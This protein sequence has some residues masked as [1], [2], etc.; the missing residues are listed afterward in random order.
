MKKSKIPRDNIILPIDTLIH[1]LTFLPEE[2]IVNVASV[3][4]QHYECIMASHSKHGQY[5]WKTLYKRQWTIQKDNHERKP[6]LERYKHKYI[7]EEEVNSKQPVKKSIIVMDSTIGFAENI[8]NHQFSY[9]VDNHPDNTTIMEYSSD[10]RLRCE[11]LV[12]C[13]G[14][15]CIASFRTATHRGKPVA[16]VMV[17]AFNI[18]T[19]RY[20]NVY[21]KKYFPCQFTKPIVTLKKYELVDIEDDY[22][23]LMIMDGDKMDT[24]DLNANCDDM[25]RSGLLI[26]DN[27]KTDLDNALYDENTDVIIVTVM[28]ACGAE[29]IINYE[30]SRNE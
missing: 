23:V 5:L 21:Q 15:P 20:L 16:I 4:R 13:D 18:F 29:R 10:Q 6:W 30:V 25:M 14:Q 3:N 22:A 11:L 12:I 27:M 9:K 19:L 7:E 28:R 17:D 1:A 26:P 8:A 2:S 24:Y